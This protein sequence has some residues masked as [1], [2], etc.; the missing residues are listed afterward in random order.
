MHLEWTNS[1]FGIYVTFYVQYDQIEKITWNEKFTS[2]LGY[3]YCF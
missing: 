1:I 3:Y 2:N